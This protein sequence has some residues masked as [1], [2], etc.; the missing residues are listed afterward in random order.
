MNSFEPYQPISDALEMEFNQMQSH[1]ANQ[2]ENF[3]AFTRIRQSHRQHIQKL[4]S[5]GGQGRQCTYP[6]RDPEY[7]VGDAFFKA[8]SKSDV[9]DNR[10]RPSVPSNLR[11]SG[12]VWRTTKSYNNMTKQYGYLCERVQ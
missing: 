3:I 6:W 7:K 12:R 2:Q 1:Q 4:G 11:L 5:G 8:C 10:G 9:D